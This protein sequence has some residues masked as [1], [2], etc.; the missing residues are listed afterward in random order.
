MKANALKAKIVERDM[1]IDS[2]CK[3]AGFVRSTFSRKL[4]GE[5][6]FT[7]DEMEKIMVVLNLSSDEMRNIFFTEC[8][9]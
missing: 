1:N 8:V 2:F 5:S 4:K 9:A 6:E 7:R 3:A